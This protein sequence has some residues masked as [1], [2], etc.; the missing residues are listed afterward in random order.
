[1]FAVVVR[2]A[3]DMDRLDEAVGGI[4]AVKQR[5]TG[6]PGFRSAYW[7]RPIDGHGLM[8]SLWAGEKEATDAAPPVGFSPAPAV[9]ITEVEIREV[10][11][12]A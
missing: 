4:D 3:I 12:E 5:L 10:I 7:R 11:A 6:L 1:M 8:V 9:E 2:T